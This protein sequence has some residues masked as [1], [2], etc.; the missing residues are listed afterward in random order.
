M[1][2]IRFVRGNLFGSQAEALVNTV[3]CVG[4]MGK[5]IAH[6]FKRA[7]PAY[8]EDY[9]TKC[10]SGKVKLGEVTH[11][12]DNGR[13]IISFPTK[14]HWKAKSNLDDI[15]T[16]LRSLRAFLEREKVHSVAL[17]PL[18]CGNGGLSWPTVKQV[19]LKELSVSTLTDIEVYEPAG[20]FESRVA[21]EP[22]VSL[23]HFVL[24]GLR[25]RLNHPTR[26]NIQKAAYFFNVL[27][28][29]DYFRFTEHKYGP[30]CVGIEPMFNTIRDYLA[31]TKMDATQMLTDGLGR[32]L[33]G[34]E[35]DRLSTWA[36]VIDAVSRFC[37]QHTKHLE[38]LATA[39]AVIAST[40]EP[41]KL[42]EVVDKFLAW[43]PEKSERFGPADV[44]AAVSMLEREG[45]V[46]RSLLGLELTPRTQ[47]PRFSQAK[48]NPGLM[49]SASP[50]PQARSGVVPQQVSS[51]NS[52]PATPNQDSS[53]AIGVDLPPELLN[54]LDKYCSIHQV[55]RDAVIVRAL[56]SMLSSDPHAEH[57]GSE[58]SH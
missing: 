17:P 53:N 23:A 22:K 31:Y 42:E 54:Q 29:T 10:R 34:G 47:I 55:S 1:P 3:N 44:S 15:I 57:E 37:N 18:G 27:S 50:E 20:H 19:I 11:F 12:R 25:S 56:R 2:V 14:N 6:Q 38:A 9:A 4:V 24:A 26:L 28:G 46:R 52:Q 35:A 13:L 48:N 40:R 7:F 49:A 8:F 39:H 16:G 33:A 32:R 58:V 30:Y 51:P 45:L 43:S 21:Q 36:P 5:G 41:V